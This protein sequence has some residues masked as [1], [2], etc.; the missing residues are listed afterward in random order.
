MDAPAAPVVEAA[1]EPDVEW[2]QLTAHPDFDIQAAYPFLI[3]KR[4]GGRI[5][6]LTPTHDGYL[7]CHI[8]GR[9]VKHHRVIAEQFLP[10][11]DNQPDIDHINHQRDDNHIENLRWLSRRDNLR[12]KSR[13]GGVQYT[14]DTELPADAIVVDEYNGRHFTNY[15]Y[16]EGQFW[17]F[18]GHAYRR[19][20]I[21]TDARWDSLSVWMIDDEGVKRH[22][23]VANYRRYIGEIV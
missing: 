9:K 14:Y 22:I 12:N 11:P 5:I 6:A 10:N 19:L 17:F 23:S 20:H 2:V 21:N 13:Q 4:R 16:H 15:Y 1:V 3:R 7:Q 8:N 18:T